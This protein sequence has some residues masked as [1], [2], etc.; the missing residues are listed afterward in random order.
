[1][2]IFTYLFIYLLNLCILHIY[3]GII[4]CE[5]KGFPNGEQYKWMHHKHPRHK[6]YF[7]KEGHLGQAN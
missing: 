5:L 2:Y 7:K 4:L 1:M 3:L 6:K